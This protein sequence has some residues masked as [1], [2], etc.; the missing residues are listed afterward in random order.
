M[1][2][3]QIPAEDM[4]DFLLKVLRCGSLR[5]RLLVCELDTI[6]VALR[7]RMLSVDH[8]I[9]AIDDLAAWDLMPEIGRAEEAHDL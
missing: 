8:A 9:R 7:G 5:A 2:A 3:A 1:N 4:H 6:G